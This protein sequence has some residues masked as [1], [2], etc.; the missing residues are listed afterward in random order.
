MSRLILPPGM[1]PYYDD[2]H[3]H[4]I[5]HGDCR[6]ILP[7][8]PKVDLVL[9]D[10]PYGLGQDRAR[11]LSRGKGG[12]NSKR[13]APATDYGDFAWDKKPAPAESIELALA[14]ADLAIIWGGNYFPLPPSRGWL[15]WDKI[16]G[17]SDFADCELAW[18]NLPQAV[19]LFRH[20][21]NGMFRE[22]EKSMPR[23]HPT[24]KP[25]ALFRWCLFFCPDAETIL[26]PFMGS[27]TTLVAAKNLGRKAI[28]IELCEEYC[29]I[30]ARRL[31]QQTLEFPDVPAPEKPSPLSL[32]EDVEPEFL[33]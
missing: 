19:R 21:W 9:T 13:L 14:S 10:P 29:E 26:D 12:P 20:R 32:W 30:G 4:V 22:S 18:T 25:L 11:V 15:V 3:G 33:R 5:L 16:N 23:L 7:Q 28:G 31:S 2:G 27:G 8:L 6:D 1:K 17:K 24:Q